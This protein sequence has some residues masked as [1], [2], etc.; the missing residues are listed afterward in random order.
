MAEVKNKIVTV[1]SL[2]ALHDYDESTY[3]KTSGGT[4]T[5]DITLSGGGDI[6][7]SSKDFYFAHASGDTSHRSVLLGSDSYDNGAS[8][9]L[10][11]KDYSSDKGRFLLRASNGTNSVNLIG[12]P[13]GTL[14]WGGKNIA[15]G[16]YLPLSGGT[17]TGNLAIQ[18]ASSPVTMLKISDTSRETRLYKNASSTADYGTYLSDYANDGTRDSLVLCRENDLANKLSISVA[19]EDGS[20]N[21]QYY[22]YGEHHKPTPSE[23]GAAAA[24]HTHQPEAISAH[25]GNEYYVLPSGGVYETL[26]LT[27]TVK[28]GTK[29]TVSNNAIKIGSGVNQV[30]ISA[31]VC[32]GSSNRTIKYL[33][34]RNNA[35]TQ[36]ARAQI[37]LVEN[38]TPQT[39]A[40]ASIVVNVAENDLLTLDFYGEESDT[41][42]GGVNLTYITV[43]KLA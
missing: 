20:A 32:V 37:K 24:S 29:L 35:T 43:E 13:D 40:V 17:I 14:T 9:Y 25:M 28:V 2:A 6:V 4:M 11:G 30:R 3:L 10:N 38:T 21:T 33:A 26:P 23:I 5:G 12:L 1:E 34:V 19:N 31:Q 16:S 18:K 22:I 42:Y 7:A 41:I 27:T 8:I 36:L 15:V 39:V